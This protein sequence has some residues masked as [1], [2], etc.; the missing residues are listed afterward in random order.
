MYNF[1]ALHNDILLQRNANVINYH[2]P[3]ILEKITI[4]TGHFR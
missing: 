3:S 4:T 1:D 2:E